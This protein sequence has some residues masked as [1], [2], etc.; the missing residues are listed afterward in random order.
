M[1]YNLYMGCFCKIAYDGPP[2]AKTVYQDEG[3][4]RKSRFF[5]A[6]TDGPLKKHSSSRILRFHG[7]PS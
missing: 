1:P 5:S 7:E 2:S 6:R 3:N 4:L